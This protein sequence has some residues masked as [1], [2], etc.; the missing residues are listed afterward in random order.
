MAKEWTSITD[1]DGKKGVR[2]RQH[3]KRKHGAIPDRYFVLTYWWKG[4]TRTEKV[5]WASEGWTPT[6]CFEILAELRRNQSIGSGPC[7]LAEMREREERRKRD[8]READREM[9]LLNI[10]FGEVF[11]TYYFPD[12]STRLDPETAR[13]TQEHVSNWILP[14][15]STMPLRDIKLVH[16][17]RIRANL[18]RESR[19]PATQRHVFQTF[20]SVWNSAVDHGLVDRVC[21]TK[22]SSFRLPRIDNERQRYLTYEE[23]KKLLEELWNRNAQVHDMSLVALDAG[24][25]FGEIAKLTWGCIDLSQKHIFVINTKSG[26]D[27][28][29]PLTDRLH[30]V[31]QSISCVYECS[32]VFPN[33][34]GAVHSQV[35]SVFKRAVSTVGLN[36]HVTDSKLRA[37]FH[38]LRH[39]FASRMVQAGIDLY[40]VQKLL[41]HSTPTMTAR[42]SKLEQ[43]NLRLAVVEMEKGR[44]RQSKTSKILPWTKKVAS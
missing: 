42:Y 38:S 40:R 7:T 10:S 39:T 18:Q 36:D 3:P 33:T 11:L 25:R 21:P 29:V 37:S 16:I 41:G 8:E 26:R 32:L 44:A 31:L 34:K 13:K 5:G 12:A 23:E 6:Q 17:Q 43:E 4:N 14:V 20:T 22:L 24:L 9:A 2:Y 1:A 19:A 35:P 27:R 15:V 28:C 30:S